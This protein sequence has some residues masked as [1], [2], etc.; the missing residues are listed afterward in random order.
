M[1]L[2]R[3]AALLLA[4][5]TA[6]ALAGCA[7]GEGAQNTDS[8]APEGTA[9]LLSEIQAR[10]ELVIALEGTWSPW[11][12]HDE[13]G[14]LT[15]YDVEVGRLIARE[16]GVE[17]AFVEG[18]WDGLFAGLDSGRY[19]MVINGVDV[20]EA[21]SE[22]YDFT[23]PYAYNRTVI[24]TRADDDRIASF[25]DLDGMHTA[26]TLASTYAAVAEQY[27]AETTG[28]D[29]LLQTIALLESGRIDATLNAEV[30]FYDYMDQHPDAALKIAAVSDDATT[31]AIPLRKGEETASL[32]EAVNGA[33]EG[34]RASGELGELSQRFFGVDISSQSQ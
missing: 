32:R 19:D 25:E 26:N 34:I 3:F 10:G 6:L 1:K 17:A 11:S 15:G 23:E 12:Y 22:K 31:V 27:G 2:R 30:T 7:G 4:G 21:R 18:Q 29:D 16:L 20:D 13:D 5:V 8:S 33:L 14:V 28:V 24:I 9:D